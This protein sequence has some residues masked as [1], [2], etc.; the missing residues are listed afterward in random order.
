LPTGFP[1]RPQPI[2]GAHHTTQSATHARSLAEAPIFDLYLTPFEYALPT[3]EA[4]LP[5]QLRDAQRALPTAAGRVLAV[6]HP[7]PVVRIFRV[8]IARSNVVCKNSAMLVIFDCDGVLVDSEPLCNRIEAAELTARGWPMTPAEARATFKGCTYAQVLEKVEAR[9][10]GVVS[11]AW[12]HESA[13]W[14]AQIFHKELKPIAGVREVVAA[15]HTR[16][17]PICVASQ[18]QLPRVLLSLQICQ[19]EHF[20]G[21]HVFTASM[22]PRPKP[23][24]DLFLHAAHELGAAPHE[25]V[26]I[27]DS[28]SGVRAAVAA[29]MKVFGYADAEPAEGLRAAG[30]QIFTRMDELPALLE[31]A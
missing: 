1:L 2:D 30:A 9:L 21:P 8:T 28:P 7:I 27:E 16:D 12:A 6:A 17:V 26:V 15:L 25:C 5:R 3:R 18:S 10:P 20:F 24:P 22:V 29:G 4:D 13:L 11:E 23:A 14:L 31:I 19:L